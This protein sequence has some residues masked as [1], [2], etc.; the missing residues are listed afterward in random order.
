MEL[1]RNTSKCMIELRPKIQGF[2]KGFVFC[3][4]LDDAR[5]LKVLFKE[6]IKEEIGA[7]FP[8]YIKHGCTEFAMKYPKY[9]ESNHDN[10]DLMQYDNSWKAKEVEFDQKFVGSFIPPKLDIVRQSLSG[11]SLS[12]VLIIRN[13]FCYAEKIGDLSFR[14]ISGSKTISK[15]ID[16]K[17][18]YLQEKIG[19]Y[20]NHDTF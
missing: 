3:S 5:Q 7:E 14:K 1:K 12:D 18:E 4:S 16:S 11:L 13:W 2:Y 9:N 15:H 19:S 10:F 8:V 20:Q 6:I 17:F